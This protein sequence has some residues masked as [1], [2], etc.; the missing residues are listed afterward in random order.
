M[1]S[2]IQKATK[3]ETLT[4][5]SLG[6]KNRVLGG[7]FDFVENG[8]GGG[9][10]SAGGPPAIFRLALE[11]FCIRMAKACYALWHLKGYKNETWT[12]IS[13]GKNISSCGRLF[14]DF[15]EDGRGGGGRGAGGPPAIFRRR[16]AGP[17]QRYLTHEK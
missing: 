7:Y 5:I 8:R 2:G 14:C 10:R 9:G 12:R 6:K 17:P 3:N 13:P 11:P 15:I 16:Q 1:H 4:R